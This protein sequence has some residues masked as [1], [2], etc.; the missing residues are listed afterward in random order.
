MDLWERTIGLTARLEVGEIPDRSPA[1]KALLQDLACRGVWS[2]KSVC[3][4]L[5]RHKDCLIAGR[6]FR[7]LRKGSKLEW[8][9]AA[10][11]DGLPG[12]Q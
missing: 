5:R 10:P 4:W 11:G 2:A 6:A 7:C 12:E 3:W 8:W 9:L 1:V